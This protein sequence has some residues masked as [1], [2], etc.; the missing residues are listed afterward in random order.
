MLITPYTLIDA[1]ALRD[2]APYAE[3]TYCLR[4]QVTTQSTTLQHA[5]ADK[6]RAYAIC[7]MPL[8]AIRYDI[9]L[10]WLT[11]PCRHIADAASR[12]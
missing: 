10:I 8:R 11:P 12:Y 2:A 5:F 1:D 7:L 4:Q 6:I 9:T 3:Y